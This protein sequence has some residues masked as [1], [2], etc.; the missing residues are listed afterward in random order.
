ML[1]LL[2]LPCCETGEQDGAP[3]YTRCR[4]IPPKFSPLYAPDPQ[5]WARSGILRL[6]E[7][8]E[9]Q[10]PPPRR[11]AGIS[12]TARFSISA[13]PPGPA[14]PARL[15]SASW[16]LLRPPTSTNAGQ[17]LLGLGVFFFFSFSFSISFSFF[18]SLSSFFLYFFFP[19]SRSSNLQTTW[20][21]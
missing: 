15:G 21:D 14:H 18:L 5:P 4:Q 1:Q 19:S 16:A 8:G 3:S 20:K 9:K 11:S 7:S 12:H 17:P 13:S 10:A 2:S 6:K